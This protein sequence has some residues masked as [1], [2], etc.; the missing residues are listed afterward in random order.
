MITPKELHTHTGACCWRQ[1]KV[2][3][4]DCWCF[5]RDASIGAWSRLQDEFRHGVILEIC[6]FFVYG[7]RSNIF[8]GENFYFFGF[9]SNIFVCENVLF[10]L[11]NGYRSNIFLYENVLVFVNRYRSNIFW[12]KCVTFSITDLATT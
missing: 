6:Y 3:C 5:N 1:I 4:C 2:A 7:Y 11:V 10:F 12:W 9:R 8:L